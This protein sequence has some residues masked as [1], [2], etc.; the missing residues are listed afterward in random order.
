MAP[1]NK[2]AFDDGTTAPAPAPA[3]HSEPAEASS[4]KNASVEGPAYEYEYEYEYDSDLPGVTQPS[5]DP[6][7]SKATTEVLVSPHASII[8]DYSSNSTAATRTPE[9]L[10]PSQISTSLMDKEDAAQMYCIAIEVAPPETVPEGGVCNTGRRSTTTTTK[11]EELEI[12]DHVY[13]WRSWMGVPGVFQHHG[14]VMDILYENSLEEGGGEQQPDAGAV[15]TPTRNSE[16]AV[17]TARLT[18]ADFSNVEHQSDH[19]ARADPV[20]QQRRRL[21]GLT[22]EGILRTYTDTDQWH[23]VEYDASWWKRSVYRAGTCTSVS[24]DATGLVLARVNYILRHPDAL[25]DYHVVNANCECVAVWCK[26]GR[27]STLQASSLLELTAAGQIKST[28]TLAA[29][30][31]SSQVTVQAPAAGLWGWLGYTSVTQVS[32]LSLHPMFIPALAGYAVFSVG[33]PAI[34]YVNARKQWK[35]TTERLKE[36]FWDD[37]MKNP[38]VFAECITHWSDK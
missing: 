30:A 31:A 23:K 16:R 35:R 1:S 2:E 33:V 8:N 24:S 36:S 18:I 28:A 26:T 10:L 12:G 11:K 17:V 27:W 15:N 4:T 38:E 19:R 25:P 3:H 20:E 14:I 37:A 9:P 34:M 13:Q 7:T 29:T 6:T 21:S 5:D 32:W 22:Q